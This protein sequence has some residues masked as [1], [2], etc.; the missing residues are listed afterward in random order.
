M[1]RLRIITWNCRQDKGVALLIRWQCFLLAVKTNHKKKIKLCLN[2]TTLGEICADITMV[3]EIFFIGFKY[4]H[5]QGEWHLSVRKIIWKIN[6]FWWNFKEMFLRFWW[7]SRL[8]TGS[9]NVLKS[10]LSLRESH[11]QPRGQ[12]PLN[13]RQPTV[14]CNLV[15]LLPIYMYVLYYWYFKLNNIPLKDNN[16]ALIP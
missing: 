4:C 2:H 12:V 14:L 8:P 7:Y 11:L 10:S 5:G 13:I 15:L 9:R 6:R 16:S 1:L 3:R